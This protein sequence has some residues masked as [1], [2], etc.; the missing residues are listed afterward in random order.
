MRILVIRGGAI[1][2][3]IVTLPA[4]ALLRDTWPN[5]HIELLGNPTPTSLILRRH[6][7]DS[8]R[9]TGHRAL[10]RFFIPDAKP[11]LEWLEH[12]A[13]FDLVL[14]YM[15]DPDDVFHSHLLRAGLSRLE[16]PAPRLPLGQH[17]LLTGNP[18][19]T[20]TPAARQ[21]CEPLALIGLTS[22]TFRSTLHPNDDDLAAARNLLPSSSELNGKHLLALHPGSGSHHKNWPLS[23]WRALLET[24]RKS[25]WH[26]VLLSGEADT[27]ET[28][29]LAPLCPTRIHQ[30]PLPVLAAVIA[31]CGH[32]LGHDSGPSHIA[33]AVGARCTLLFGPTDPAVW[34]PP[35]LH[36]TILHP[37]DF[38]DAIPLDS[39]LSALSD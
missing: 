14:S 32:F 17:T 31:Q 27:E 4:L 26:P 22:S 7:L 2:D 38:M 10:A 20:S 30:Q 9:S 28:T 6:Y 11:D 12:L 33:A 16:S 1:G 23:K 25:H 8:F 5:A 35:E 15:Y 3:L 34:A 37:G 21:L 39:V 18:R 13:S 36:G 24:L 19:I 29:A